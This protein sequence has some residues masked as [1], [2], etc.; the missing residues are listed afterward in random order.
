M[1]SWFMCGSLTGIANL[2]IKTNWYIVQNVITIYINLWME[3]RSDR[4]FYFNN[5]CRVRL[6]VVICVPKIMSINMRPRWLNGAFSFISIKSWLISRKICM[7]NVI[8]TLLM[9]LLCA[10]LCR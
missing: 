7:E 1:K 2:L 8:V 4:V 5:L 3:K 9:I 6:R 10:I